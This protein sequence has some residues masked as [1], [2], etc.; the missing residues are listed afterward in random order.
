MLIPAVKV[1]VALA[2]DGKFQSPK[3]LQ[4][5][6]RLAWLLTG[7]AHPSLL[8]SACPLF[9]LKDKFPVAAP[10]EYLFGIL[11]RLATS[12]ECA[13]ARARVHACTCVCACACVYVRV[14]VCMRV[15]ACVRACMCVPP[16]FSFISSVRKQPDP[17]L[18]MTP[19]CSQ[20]SLLSPPCGL[21]QETAGQ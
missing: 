4:P 10:Q 5:R 15:R 9:S 14:R 8:Y 7:P 19:L 16:Q 2:Q 6:G 18:G 20:S 12:S 13:C 11:E 17:H 3:L 21:A 1:K